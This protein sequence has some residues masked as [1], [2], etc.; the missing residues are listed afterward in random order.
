MQ[1]PMLGRS[2]ITNQLVPKVIVRIEIFVLEH[3]FHTTPFKQESE[4]PGVYVDVGSHI[5]HPCIS[6]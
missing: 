2:I 3:M 1:T 5:W 4:Y 6:M